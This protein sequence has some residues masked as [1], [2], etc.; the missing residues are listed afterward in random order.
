MTL[1]KI[2]ASRRESA[3]RQYFDIETRNLA[4]ALFRDDLKAF[5]YEF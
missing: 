1:P 5:G 3:Y 2:N 4:E